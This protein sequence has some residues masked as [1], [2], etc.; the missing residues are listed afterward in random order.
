MESQKREFPTYPCV[1]VSWDNSPRRGQDGII[2]TNSSPAIFES[3][4]S[5]RVNSMIDRPYDDRLIFINAW[6]EWAEGNYLEPDL[7]YGTQYLDA[8]SRVM[9]E[10]KS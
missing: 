6:N 8:V 2:M 3:A 1:F 7:K 4:L 10:P 5:R 9:F